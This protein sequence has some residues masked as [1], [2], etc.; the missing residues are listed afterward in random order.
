MNTESK[1]GVIKVVKLRI[2][3]MTDH[4]VLLL[5]GPCDSGSVIHEPEVA[6]SLSLEYTPLGT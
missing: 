3:L 6:V 2:D 4:K 5:S 1:C